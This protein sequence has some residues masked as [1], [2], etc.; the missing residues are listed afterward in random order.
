M[1][2]LSNIKIPTIEEER[3]RLL[4]LIDNKYYKSQGSIF[5]DVMSV[6]AEDNIKMYSRFTDIFKNA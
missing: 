5:Y 4:S 6:I 2:D 1:T 3:D